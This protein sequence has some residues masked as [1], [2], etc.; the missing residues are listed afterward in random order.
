MSKLEARLRG[1]D[2]GRK[3]DR[4]T[5]QNSDCGWHG[6]FAAAYLI[7]SPLLP[8][9]MPISQSALEEA[10]RAAIPCTHLEVID[11]SS[12]CGDKY[13]VLVVSDAF[14]G[15]TTLARHRFS[16]F[17][18]ARRLLEVR[19]NDLS[20]NE[21]LKKEIAEIHA[22]SQVLVPPLYG[23]RPAHFRPH[24][25]RSRPSNTKRIWPSLLH[26]AITHLVGPLY[27]CI[28]LSSILRVSLII[29]DAC[30]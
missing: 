14:A 8:P 11:E 22:F 18:L 30:R 17:G 7:A 6:P 9:A 10:I 26:E 12:G 23:V 13:A 16:Q 28:H 5:C 25:K 27:I 4:K 21:V 15:K 1:V 24:R 2:E 19:L 20:V 3:E 29:L